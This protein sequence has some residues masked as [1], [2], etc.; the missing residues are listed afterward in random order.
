[1]G[2]FLVVLLPKPIKHLLLRESVAGRRPGGLLLEGSV[3]PLMARILL[4][5]PGLDPQ[6][7]DPQ[8][9]PPNGQPGKSRHPRGRK[10][11]PVIRKNRPGESILSKNLPKDLLDWPSCRGR[12]GSTGEQITAGVIGNRQRI[13]VASIPGSKL[14]FEVGCENLVG[15]HLSQLQGRVGRT[16]TPPSPSLR[17][18]ES[19]LLEDLLGCG[20]CR[21]LHLRLSPL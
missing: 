8:S 13:A 7:L 6:R 14:S 11:G 20:S 10:R 2:A 3:H 9:N 4:R 17:L 5:M 19:G 16:L 1:M 21:P 12:E 18:D 15:S